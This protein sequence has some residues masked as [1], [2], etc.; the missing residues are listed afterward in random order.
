MYN[1]TVN[2]LSLSGR[3]A[4]SSNTYCIFISTIGP[5]YSNPSLK[6]IVINMMI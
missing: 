5:S 3:W 1:Y 4:D 6:Y 2:T